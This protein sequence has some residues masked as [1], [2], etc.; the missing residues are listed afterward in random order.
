VKILYDF[1][2]QDYSG[3]VYK[4]HMSNPSLAEIIN[5]YRQ[6]ATEFNIIADTLERDYKV[7]VPSPQK[8]TPAAGIAEMNAETIKAFIK[9]KTA[10]RAA[11]IAEEFKSNK[12]AV[13]AIIEANPDLFERAEKGWIKVK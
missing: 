13:S 3:D 9:K 4:H 1:C 11:T 6:K 12:E 8:L 7:K 2:G 10:A 5:D